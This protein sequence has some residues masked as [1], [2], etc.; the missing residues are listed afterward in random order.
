MN[1]GATL[2]IPLRNLTYLT[3]ALYF[4]TPYTLSLGI[5]IERWPKMS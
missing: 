5:E 4:Y 2:P 1:A 3:S